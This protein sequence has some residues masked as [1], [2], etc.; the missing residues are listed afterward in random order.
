M[1]SLHSHGIFGV[2]FTFEIIFKFKVIF[3][4]IEIIFIFRVVVKFAVIFIFEVILKFR[5]GVKHTQRRVSLKFARFFGVFGRDGL[6]GLV[7][8][9]S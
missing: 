8:H 6:V 3:M 4:Y 7:W 9:L 2:I 1:R 5:D